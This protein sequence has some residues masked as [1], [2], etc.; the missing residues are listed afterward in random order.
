MMD[1]V[2][3]AAKGVGRLLVAK[4][5]DAE[6]LHIHIS[7]IGPGERPHP[8]HTHA[9]LEAIYVLEGNGTLEVDGQ[10]YPLGANQCMLLDTTRIHGLLNTGTAKMR[11]M[12]IITH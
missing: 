10:A 1:F 3:V 12:V 6:R 5:V 9:G 2:E 7:E 11:Y 4:G 8:P